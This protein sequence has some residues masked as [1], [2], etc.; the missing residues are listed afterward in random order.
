M[1]MQ[2]A[3]LNAIADAGAAL[4]KYIGL[5]DEEGTEISGGSPAYARKSVTWTSASGGTIRPSSD[6]TFDVPGGKTVGGWRGYSAASGGTNYGGVDYA[7]DKQETFANQGTYK[8][9]ANQT[10]INHE[11]GA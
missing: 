7:S 11:A 5:V 3:Y 8:L 2:T 9:L 6:L 1:A 10:A 4:I